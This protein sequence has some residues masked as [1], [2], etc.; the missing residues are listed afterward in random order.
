M[1]VLTLQTSGL[2]KDATIERQLDLPGLRD[3]LLTI[4]FAALFNN[5]ESTTG[6]RRV[7]PK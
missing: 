2:T 5:P 7:E 1:T 6:G 3:T 4:N